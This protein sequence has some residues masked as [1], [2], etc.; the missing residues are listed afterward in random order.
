MREWS[1]HPVKNMLRIVGGTSHNTQMAEEIRLNTVLSRDGAKVVVEALYRCDTNL[2]RL[3]V[4]IS[5]MGI[6]RARELLRKY[7]FLPLE[8]G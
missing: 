2:H 1:L 6:P 3:A 4:L 8:R 5:H 7:D